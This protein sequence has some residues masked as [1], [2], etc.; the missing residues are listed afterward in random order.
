MPVQVWSMRGSFTSVTVSVEGSRFLPVG[1]FIRMSIICTSV[2]QCDSPLL[3]DSL[4]TPGSTSDLR[5]KILRTALLCCFVTD[6]E[7][8][9]IWKCWSIDWNSR[10]IAYWEEKFFSGCGV[11]RFFGATPTPYSR[12]MCTPLRRTS[13][14]ENLESTL[15]TP[16][17]LRSNWKFDIVMPI[18]TYNK[19]RSN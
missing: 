2:S 1:P 8:E 6:V 17:L 10:G 19:L 15:L 9:K 16:V 11:S 4:T 3:T 18:C 14:E 12:L 7:Q 5:S 13:N